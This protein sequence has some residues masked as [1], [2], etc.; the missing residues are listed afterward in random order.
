MMVTFLPLS[1]HITEMIDMPPFVNAPDREA[2]T[3]ILI[4][5]LLLSLG[6]TEGAVNHLQVAKVHKCDGPTRTNQLACPQ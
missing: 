5:Q 1:Q 3:H 2:T 6:N 4:G